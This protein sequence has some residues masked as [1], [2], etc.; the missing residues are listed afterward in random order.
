MKIN[1]LHSTLTY[2]FRTS[3]K[4]APISIIT[5]QPDSL[6]LARDKTDHNWDFLVDLTGPTADSKIDGFTL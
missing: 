3:F 5:Y 4:Q 2:W 1:W 6:V